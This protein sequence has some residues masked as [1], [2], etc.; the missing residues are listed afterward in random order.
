M[1]PNAMFRA[2]III[3]LGVLTARAEVRLHHLFTDHMVLQ[4]GTSV[5]VWGWA[6]EG[7]KITVEFAGQKASTTVK[8]GKWMVKLKN[9]KPGAPDALRVRSVS[10]KG[11]NSL[12]QV[13]DVV[14]GEVW[15][16]SGQS[17][18]EW[19]L[20]RSFN[21]TNDMANSANA[22]IR[23]F[24][25]PKLKLNEP[26]NDVNGKW[27]LCAP[28]AVPGF[29]AVAYYFARDLQKA[30]GVPVGVI[31]TSW[32]G[33]PAEVWMSEEVLS[34]D[35]EYKRDILDTYDTQAQRTKAAITQWE[36]ERADAQKEG[37]QFTKRRPSLAWKPAE[38]YN[39][40]IANIIPYAIKGAIWYQ[41]ESNAGR[42]WQYRHLFTD[43]IENW[44]N[45]WDRDFTFL[46][47][48]LAPYDMS[49][50]R[51]LDEITAKPDDS[52][53]AE[54][55]EA[56][57]LATKNLK[58]VGMAVI[59]DVGDK[60]DIHP[61]KKEPVGARLAL[62]ARK[63]AYGEKLVAAG[64]EF[65]GVK[66]KD[67]KAIL[68][69]DNVGGGLEARG[70]ALT[71]FTIAGTNKT[72]VWADA[73]IEGDKV[74]VTWSRAAGGSFNGNGKVVAVRYGWSDFPVVN[75][76]NKEGLPATPFRTDDWQMTT[77]PKPAVKAAAKP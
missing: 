65:D 47:V 61:T 43:M 40:M 22:Q 26:T 56:Q 70:G 13:S 73:K 76:F 25:V 59:T 7:D 74:V 62:Q 41:G 12:V 14:V 4:Q 48:Q 77:A 34:G 24:T 29:S 49:R 3:A 58:K 39:G 21:S 32:G 6:D 72:F 18:M 31:H 15:I 69:F 33:S 75:L 30:L 38:L 9:L 46:E 54:L 42:A 45:E 35:K 2:F 51:S 55:R 71:G 19:P 1:K 28:D 50:K 44:R 27:Q 53:W 67:S 16:A 64:P 17:N 63:I 57:L 10:A 36:K 68:S 8:N 66:F 11:D 52:A 20:N 5:P 60:D 37:K 23:L